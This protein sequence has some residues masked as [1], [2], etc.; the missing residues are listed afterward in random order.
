M[1]P[2]MVDTYGQIPYTK[3]QPVTLSQSY[4]VIYS[5]V[6]TYKNANHIEC[7]YGDIEVTCVCFY[8]SCLVD[9][10]EKD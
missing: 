6:Y 7:A 8:L 2:T 3:C 1:F 5:F 4:T 10:T 9:V